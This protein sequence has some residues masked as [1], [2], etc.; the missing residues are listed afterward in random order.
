MDIEYIEYHGSE[1]LANL[2]RVWVIV[3]IS[4]LNSTGNIFFSG[5]KKKTASM[6]ACYLKVTSSWSERQPEGF[7]MFSFS[8]QGSSQAFS[9]SCSACF[10]T[11]PSESLY[12]GLCC[13]GTS[14]TSNADCVP[15]GI[16]TGTWTSRLD[17]N[18]QQI[19]YTSSYMA[20]GGLF[21]CC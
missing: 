18:S 16:M 6:V 1:N 3:K 12:N 5:E 19:A 4:F 2:S 7:G 14:Y 20:N 11:N 9:A 17:K 10:L 21:L 15:A 8:F 13:C